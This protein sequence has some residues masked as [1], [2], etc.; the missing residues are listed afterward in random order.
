MAYT[1]HAKVA[2]YLGMTLSAGQQTLITNDLEPAMRLYIDRYTG[3]SWET[4]SP[5]T[6]EL[7]T[8]YGGVVYLKQRPVTAIT[9]ASYRSQSIG[10]ESTALTSGSTYELLD[11][12]NGTMLAYVPDGSLV[13]VS[14]THSGTAVPADIAH[15][16]TLLVSANLYDALLSAPELRGLK[17]YSVGS[18]DLSLTF[19]TEQSKGY[20]SSA[21][22]MLK[23]RRSFV[24]A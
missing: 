16:A 11:A 4:S 10:S 9:A 19:D 17:Q 7:H 2:A 1:T 21:L 3:R 13:S 12:T 5:V 24:F 22:D 14:Y 6:A 15:A 8:V 23:L 18:G 20:A